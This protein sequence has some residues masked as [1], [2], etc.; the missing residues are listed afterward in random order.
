MQYNAIQF[1]IIEIIFLIVSLLKNK[2]IKKYLFLML[3]IFYSFFIGYRDQNVGIDTLAYI[4]EY[5][6]GTGGYFSERGFTLLGK[7]LYKLGLS[8]QE[9][10]T[11]LSV[12]TLNTYYLGYKNNFCKKEN[13]FLINWIYFFNITAL[14]GNVNGIRQFIAGSFLLLS[15]GFLEKKKNILSYL[16]FII[17]VLFHKSL[18]IFVFLYIRYIFKIFKKLTNN[19][20]IL[21]LI[22]CMILSFVLNYLLLLN[23]Q[24]LNYSQKSF[25]KTF[26][27]KYLF[28]WIIYLLYQKYKNKELFKEY[29]F[30]YAF[31]TITIFINF[32]HLSNRF[33]YYIN[34]F[35]PMLFYQLFN[36]KN[37][38]INQK[39]LILL[40]TIYHILILFY[41]ST[42]IMFKF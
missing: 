30:F 19:Q 7:Y 12:L 2:K 8:Y 24:V 42:R 40:V 15:I 14:Y 37:K 31:L 1:I 20:K 18:I 10:F 27:I 16:F 33:I 5:L 22:I 17:G 36:R 25:N 29:I 35:T 41:P 4:N 3:I 39:T 21:I 23:N 9:Y 6:T 28:L 34:I 32:E 38:I 13:Y 26:Y 11:F